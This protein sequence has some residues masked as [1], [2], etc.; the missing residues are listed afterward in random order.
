MKPLSLD[1]IDFLGKVGI[2]RE[3]NSFFKVQ[4]TGV[5]QPDLEYLFLA[6]QPID[7][8]VYRG[9]ERLFENSEEYQQEFEFGGSVDMMTV[10]EDSVQVMYIGELIFDKNVVMK[11]EEQNSNFWEG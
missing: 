10:L 9:R 11:F 5:R 3:S 4:V 1:P 8:L 7:N 6:L 2:Y